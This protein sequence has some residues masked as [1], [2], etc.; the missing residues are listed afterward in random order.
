MALRAVGAVELLRLDRCWAVDRVRIPR[1]PGSVRG[2]QSDTLRQTSRAARAPTGF[3]RGRRACVARDP[4]TPGYPVSQHPSHTAKYPCR[5]PL[6]SRRL[7]DSDR[8]VQVSW[9][10]FHSLRRGATDD[11]SFSFTC[12]RKSDEIFNES[13]KMPLD[14]G[15]TVGSMRS[16]GSDLARRSTCEERTNVDRISKH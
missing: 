12:Q 15:C 13:L 4:S 14:T 8:P 11:G 10:G 9:S 1:A 16:A 5:H 3:A 7:A 2:S 6:S